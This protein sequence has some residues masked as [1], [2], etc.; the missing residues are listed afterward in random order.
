MW[1][2]RERGCSCVLEGSLAFSGIFQVRLVP[3]VG[4]PLGQTFDINNSEGITLVG[5]SIKDR[6]GTYLSCQP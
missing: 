3:S 5:S 2:V 1:L 6:N 4:P